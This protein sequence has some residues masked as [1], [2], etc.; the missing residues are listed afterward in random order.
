MKGKSKKEEGRI[1][2]GEQG[3]GIRGRGAFPSGR[4]K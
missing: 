2:K 3:L 1:K 4:F